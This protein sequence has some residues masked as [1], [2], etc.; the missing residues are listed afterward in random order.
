M[1]N[2]HGFILI[3]LITAV[4]VNSCKKDNEFP[5][6]YILDSFSAGPVKLFT[7]TGEITDTHTINNFIADQPDYFWR[8]EYAADEWNVEIELISESSAKISD[9]DT[10][11]YFD[12]VRENGLLFFQYQGT[13]PV[14]GSASDERLKY[15]PLSFY[16]WYY[17]IESANE[18][19]FPYVSYIE[20]I[21][22]NNGWLI[23]G[24]GIDNYNNEFNSDYLVGIQNETYLTDTIAFQENKIVF[25]EK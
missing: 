10:T 25:F 16:S 22:D 18:I 19:Y 14:F 11:V 6:K 1:K 5:K 23:A 24:N 7:N 2:F 13:T 20:K 4:T 12:L 9:S 15:P 3:M 8:T 21:Y 17:A